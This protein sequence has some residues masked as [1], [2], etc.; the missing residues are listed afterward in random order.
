M[1]KITLYKDSNF[2][3]R[4]FPVDQDI[5]NLK[6]YGFNDEAS[7]CRI[8]SGTW[9]L[10]KDSNFQGDISILGKGDYASS[11]AMGL[12][13][14]SLSSL[15]HYPEVSGPT[16]LLFK[17]TNYRGRMVVLT[18]A[19]SNFKNIDFNDEVSSIIVLE[20]QWVLYKDSE[21]RGDSWTLGPGLYPT[22]SPFQNDAISSAKPI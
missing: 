11:G 20:G 13:N 17:D 16:I 22:H 9:M 12:S 21:F 18:G 8:E 15:R 5:S 14:D 6:D 10:Y 2:G 4:A 3:G 19:Q 7:S 1:A